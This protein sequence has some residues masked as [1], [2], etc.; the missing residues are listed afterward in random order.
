MVVS[1]LSGAEKLTPPCQYTI[2]ELRERII[3]AEQDFAAGRF[4]RHED[5]PRKVMPDSINT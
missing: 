5:I 3:Q 4:I 1:W 2:E